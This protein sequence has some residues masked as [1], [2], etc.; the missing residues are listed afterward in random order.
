MSPSARVQAPSDRSFNLMRRIAKEDVG[1]RPVWREARPLRNRG[2]R[3]AISGYWTGRVERCGG[4]R[5]FEII[6]AGGA[7]FKPRGVLHTRS[8]QAA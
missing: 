6:A 2:R 7:C 3:R 5:H 1:E 8:P 4:P